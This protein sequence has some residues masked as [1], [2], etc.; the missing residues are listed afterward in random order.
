MYFLHFILI[1]KYLGSS[2]FGILNRGRN[3][4]SFWIFWNDCF[5]FLSCALGDCLIALK[6]RIIYIRAWIFRILFWY[7]VE[8]SGFLSLTGNGVVEI[9]K[10]HLLPLVRPYLMGILSNCIDVET[11]MFLFVLYIIFLSITLTIS[12]VIFPCV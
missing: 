4:K 5:V 6:L 1:V 9:Y 8:W 2:L 10:Y 12:F 3:I 11:L 7:L